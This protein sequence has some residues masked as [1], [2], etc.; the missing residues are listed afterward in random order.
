MIRAMGHADISVYHMNEGHSSLLALGL[1]G[2]RLGG[3]NSAV[4]EEDIA[5]VR[6]RCVFTTHTPVPAGHD[7]FPIQMVRTILGEARA[8]LLEITGSYH[9]GSLNMTYL[10]LRFSHYING[11]AMH[12]GEISRGVFPGYP[13]HAI[14]NGVHAVTWT[15]PPFRELYD[16]HLA[17]WRKDN[18]YL[19]Y[20]IG[21]PF[22]EIADAHRK[23]KRTLIQEVKQR[24]G[25]TLDR[26]TANHRFRAACDGLQAPGAALRQH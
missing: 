13:I 15:S 5:A 6:R 9:D 11:V 20:A 24:V 14:T 25:V 8:N 7:K 17:G 23:A 10:G 22:E 2:Q 19:R 3:R 18:L 26:Q 4:V 21:I 16:R 12:H 1:L